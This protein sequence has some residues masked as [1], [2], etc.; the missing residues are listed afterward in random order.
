MQGTGGVSIFGLQ[1]AKACNTKVIVTS[2]S[3]TMLERAKGLG[4]DYVVN[5][6]KTPDWDEEVMRI[7]EGCGGDV[8]FENGGAQTT[9]N[10]FDCICFEV[11]Y[12]A[13]VTFL[14]RQI[15]RKT[16]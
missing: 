12:K 15:R 1:I 8:I 6:R 16:E 5:Y 7:S 9:S 10:F 14:A 4:A 11:A 13:L 2:S 3:D